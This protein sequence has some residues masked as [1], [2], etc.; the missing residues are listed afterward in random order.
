MSF[1]NNDGIFSHYCGGTL[2]S[3]SYTLTAGH[4]ID[5]MLHSS[6]ETWLLFGSTIINGNFPWMVKRE[7]K[8]VTYHPNYIKGVIIVTTI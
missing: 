4:C 3:E 7:V 2:V 5:K 6:H 1:H 8:S